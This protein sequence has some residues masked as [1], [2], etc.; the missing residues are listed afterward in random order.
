MKKRC[1]ADFEK[2]AMVRK[3]GD[4]LDPP[5]GPDPECP[6][7]G[8]YLDDDA[9]HD[10]RCPECGEDLHQLTKEEIDSIKGDE[11][12]HRRVDEGEGRFYSIRTPF[13]KKALKKTKGS[14]EKEA[15]LEGHEF[16]PERYITAIEESMEELWQYIL[17]LPHEQR[18]PLPK[19]SG[20]IKYYIEGLRWILSVPGQSFSSLNNGL[21]KEAASD[22]TQAVIDYLLAKS[23]GADHYLE[24]MSD[25]IEEYLGEGDD[26]WRMPGFIQEYVNYWKDEGAADEELWDEETKQKYPQAWETF[27][28]LFK[29]DLDTV[30][31]E[32]VEQ[33]YMDA[34]NM[35][36]NAYKRQ[37]GEPESREQFLAYIQREYGLDN[38]GRK[39]SGK[40]A[41][42]SIQPI[43][44]DTDPD[45]RDLEP[46][47]VESLRDERGRLPVE[48]VEDRQGYRTM[49]AKER[50]SLNKDLQQFNTY[51]DEIPAQGIAEVLEAH[52]FDGRVMDGIY[53]GEQGKMDEKIA[54]NSILW[55]TWYKM[56]S[57][58]YEIVVAAS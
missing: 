30:E 53:T 3:G 42:Y 6:K 19:I 22:A 11:E 1:V 4:F 33:A 32:K 7:C 40:T 50:R 10:E 29:M 36:L 15:A 47:E 26:Y 28:P 55:M 39:T 45:T 5:D 20:A 44:W 23:G 31:W 46:D 49:T 37:Y 24:I 18:G 13:E 2:M 14:V 43:Q 12:Y 38:E 57:G 51:L 16:N 25:A 9:I 41:D 54:K 17:T 34:F 52:G 58:R 21:E 56:P 8:A 35:E 48:F 27:S